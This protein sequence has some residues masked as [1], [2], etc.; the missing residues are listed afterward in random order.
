MNI[1][2]HR[3]KKFFFTTFLAINSSLQF[4]KNLRTLDG[5]QS[6]SAIVPLHLRNPSLLN[7]H[8][9]DIL[10]FLRL[11][12]LTILLIFFL[13][14]LMFSKPSTLLQ[15]F[16][17]PPDLYNILKRI[18]LTSAEPLNLS[19]RIILLCFPQ[20]LDSLL[21]ILNFSFSHSTF[22]LGHIQLFFL[23]LKLITNLPLHL[24]PP[25]SLKA[26]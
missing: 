9:L 6:P 18:R 25:F 7:S 16:L 4:W 8:F 13:P 1:A 23:F 14:L 22:P 24:A 19:G 10:Y 5:A 15:S 12:P 21:Y 2:I 26:A 3:E 17:S 20:C 11:I